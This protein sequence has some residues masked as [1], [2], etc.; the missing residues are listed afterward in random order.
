MIEKSKFTHEENLEVL[1]SYYETYKALKFFRKAC[2]ANPADH[3]IESDEISATELLAAL[4]EEEYPMFKHTLNTFCGL[5]LRWNTPEGIQDYAINFVLWAREMFMPNIYENIAAYHEM[6]M[7]LVRS[8][9]DLNFGKLIIVISSLFD[10]HN[11]LNGAPIPK[12]YEDFASAQN[13]NLMDFLNEL[14]DTLYER[15]PLEFI[16]DDDY[17][18]LVS[19]CKE[20]N[21]PINTLLSKSNYIYI[22]DIYMLKNNH[23]TL[24]VFLKERVVER[25]LNPIFADCI[26]YAEAI[27][28]TSATNFIDLYKQESHLTDEI[29][30]EAYLSPNGFDDVLPKI[31][32][33]EL[34]ATNMFS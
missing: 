3:G 6:D 17:A 20:L 30:Q 2:D 19:K 16:E 10:I 4:L 8:A 13:I 18:W 27:A 28:K 24:D 7:D 14:N 12:I 25:E 1:A 31:N 23:I 33:A 15:S 21:I 26:Q 9:V 11:Y 22:C 32:T 5:G 34:E 29:I